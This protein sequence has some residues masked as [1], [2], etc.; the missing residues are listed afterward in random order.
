[1]GGL[2]DG[3]RCRATTPSPPSTTWS[4]A[5][6]SRTA[7][8]TACATSRGSCATST[9]SPRNC[10]V[11]DLGAVLAAAFYHDAVYDPRAT[12]NEDQSARLAV[13]VLG[14]LG[15]SAARCDTVARLVRA[16]AGHDA[17]GDADCAVL[18]DAD[19]AVLGAEPA[20]YQAY[21]TGVRAEYAHLDAAAWRTGRAAVLRDLLARRPLYATGAGSGP[22]GGQGRR[23]HGRRAGHALSGA[24]ALETGR[25]RV[26]E[27]SDASTRRGSADATRRTR[28]GI[29]PEPGREPPRRWPLR[30]ARR[31]RS[32]RA[33]EPVYGCS[34]SLPRCFVRPAI[35]VDWTPCRSPVSHH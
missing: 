8:T 31:A 24:A 16:T 29:R 23:Q 14:E 1:M 3:G 7:A 9:S 17:D 18:L 6:A 30:S 11:S 25:A 12:D 20:A 35:V 5:T 22:V 10:P 26:G 15:W 28:T 34:P 13:R 2:D 19:L 27:P 21:V 32:R 4:V 33:W